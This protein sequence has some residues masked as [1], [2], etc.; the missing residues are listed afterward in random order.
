[1]KLS[2]LILKAIFYTAIISTFLAFSIS[3]FFEYKNFLK[4][5]EQIR[6]DF[7]NQ[8]KNEIKR[9]VNKMYDYISYNEKNIKIKTK[10]KLRNRVNDAYLIAYKIYNKYK[11]TKNEKE[12]QYLIITSL[13]NITYESDTYFF[14]NSNQGRAIL[15]NKK[16]YLEDNKDIWN[17]KDEKGNYFIQKQSNIALNKKEGFVDNYFIKPNTDDNKS[18]DKLS[19]IKLFEPYNWHIGMGFYIDDL[20]RESKNEVL[21]YIASIRY[22]KDGYFF[23][24]TLDKKALIHDGKEAIPPIEYP[25]ESLFKKQLEALKNPDGGFFF[26]KFKK[27]NS[28][29]E[30]YEKLAFVKEY[31]KWRWIIGTGSYMDELDNELLKKQNQLKNAIFTKSSIIL[32]I[33]VFLF[34]LIYFVSKR[35]TSFIESNIINLISLF[36]SASSNLKKINL[37]K[38]SFTEFRTIAKKL[39]KTLKLRNKAEKRVRDLL[40]I[41]NKNVII[42]T[43]DAKGK[44]T[45][46]N[47]SFCKISGYAEEELIGKSHNIVRHPDIPKETYKQMWKALLNG[48]IWEGELKNKNKNGEIYWVK[49]TI[50]PTY[51]KGKI[52]GYTGIKQN[53]TDKKRVEY[54]SIT[55][56]LTQTYNR[57]YF[58]TKIEEEIN[59]AKRNNYFLA[60]IMLDIDYFKLY[61]DTYGHQK[62]DEALV[63]VSEIL[64]KNTAR[65]SDFAFRLG[66]EEFGILFSYKNE[67]ESLAYANSIKNEIEAL[68]IEHKANKISPYLTISIGLVVTKGEKLQSADS[69]YKLVD[70]ALYKAK[71]TGR[72]KVCISI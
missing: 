6:S 58:N 10:E 1:M 2:N 43:T 15:F 30:K 4:E 18:Y 16:S 34:I 57:R 67:E 69:V 26:Y 41:V 13:E 53:I 49:I 51:H 5:S 9:E 7:I 36:N 52:K 68:R 55:D 54:L 14:I 21:K 38:F 40:E 39:N 48:N 22:G 47:D 66:G 35:I 11:N 17:L 25:N 71:E 64:I 45:S 37:D 33:F 63:K 56:E 61:N 28:A 70:E 23:I 8:K 12:I 44:I 72:N 62:G 24:N 32:L 20:T 60:F 59:R 42:S 50:Y 19:F 29:D 65:A 27:L 3:T 31:A 46:A